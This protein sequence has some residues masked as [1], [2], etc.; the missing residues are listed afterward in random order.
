MACRTVR[1]DDSWWWCGLEGCKLPMRNPRYIRDCVLHPCQVCVDFPTGFPCGLLM[2][3]LLAS[4]CAGANS[5]VN[6]YSDYFLIKPVIVRKADVYYLK[7]QCSQSVLHPNVESLITENACCFYVSGF[8][9]PLPNTYNVKY[10][11]LDNQMIKFAS[12]DNIF[13][14]NPDGSKIRLAV[15]V[16]SRVE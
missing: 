8:I 2:A 9:S 1:F 5:V 10:F 16:D 7:Y 6:Y 13:W 14:I 15:S 11:E 4:S 12:S 3:I